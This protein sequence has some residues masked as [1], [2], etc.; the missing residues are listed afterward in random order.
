MKITFS[1]SLMLIALLNFCN[2]KSRL[3][4]Y[5]YGFGYA[6]L[7]GGK[8]GTTLEGDQLSLSINSPAS[9]VADF[10]I[11]LDYANVESG[12]NDHSS[13]AIGIDY[14]HSFNNL[15]IGEGLFRPF[16]GAGIGFLKDN[17]Q[18]RLSNDEMIWTLCFGSE[19]LMTDEFSLAL[20][21]KYIGA[22][23][24][25]G[26]TD[27]SFDVGLTWWI[28][29]VHGIALEYSR[30]LENEIDFIGFKYLYSWQ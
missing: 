30:T 8:G 21:G 9:D 29:A 2:A 16:V 24:D 5:Y 17:A 20:G 19:I 25:F 27:F 18:A 14:L 11:Y 13:W 1:I 26:S 22:W 7:D 10:E 6:M 12:P 15:G 23:T 28:D 3:G 4:E